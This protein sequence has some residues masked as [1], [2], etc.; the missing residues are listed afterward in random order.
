MPVAVL[1]WLVAPADPPDINWHGEGPA[2]EDRRDGILA[3]NWIDI[4]RAIRRLDARRY[5]SLVLWPSAD[6]RE[7]WTT[8]DFGFL[9]VIGGDGLYVVTGCTGGHPPRHLYFPEWPDR[10]VIVLPGPWGYRDAAWADSA[11][12]VCRDVQMVL[13]AARYYA[14]HTDLDPSLPWDSEGA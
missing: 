1:E 3:P 4:K 8:G 12:R 5:R 11:R 10:D 7:H 13:Q 14:E 6:K 2:D 9:S